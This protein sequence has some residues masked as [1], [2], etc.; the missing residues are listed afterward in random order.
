MKKP[1]SFQTVTAI[2]AASALFLLPSQLC[3]GKPK[4]PVICSSSPYS[5]V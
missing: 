4:A 1:A 3:A 5:G 2:S